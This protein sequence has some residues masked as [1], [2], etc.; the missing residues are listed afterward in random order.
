VADPEHLS[1]DEWTTDARGYKGR[2]TFGAAA[3]NYRSMVLTP[4]T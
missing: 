3:W 2:D 1:R 4:G